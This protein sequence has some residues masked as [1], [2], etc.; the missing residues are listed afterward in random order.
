MKDLS[1]GEKPKPGSLIFNE[2]I[3]SKAAQTRQNAQQNSSSKMHKKKSGDLLISQFI[4]NE[5]LLSI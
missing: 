2:Q 5:S 1:S 4:Y 3:I